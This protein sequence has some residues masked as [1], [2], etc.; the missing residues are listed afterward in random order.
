MSLMTISTVMAQG[1]TKNLPEGTKVSGTA[2]YLR[3]WP[4]VDDRGQAY[5][6]IY[7]PGAKKVAVDCRGRFEMKKD[8]DG[9]WN[10]HTTPLDKGLHFYN[11]IVDGAIVTDI[12][13][14]T[15]GGSYGRCSAVEIPEGSEGDYYRPH[16]VPHGIVC[17]LTYFSTVEQ[18]YRRCNVYLLQ[19]M[20]PT[21]SIATPC[22]TCSMVCAKMKRDGQNRARLPT[23]S[24][25]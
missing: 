8:K 4:R 7:A 11:F 22:S 21:T 17:N 23:F 5:F 19:N 1:M 6:R 16:D 13:T 3:Q 20:M 25:T 12:N 15:Y 24:T 10:G 14:R 9:Y 18:R 2:L